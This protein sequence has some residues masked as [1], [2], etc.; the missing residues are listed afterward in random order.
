[1]G[2]DM[3]AVIADVKTGEVTYAV[4]DTKF[5]G[6][7]IKKGDIIGIYGVEIVVKGK[8]VDAVTGELLQKMVDED[9][10]LISI[11]FGHEV[12]EETAES[13]AESLEADFSDCD[14]E[15]NDGGQPLYYYIV[16]VE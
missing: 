4:R 14:I 12:D 6:L 16:S 9:S 7:K 5:N 1:N 8:N 13:L 3:Q 15:V 10:E 2:D 11:Y